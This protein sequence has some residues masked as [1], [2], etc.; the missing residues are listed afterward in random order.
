VTSGKL[1]TPPSAPYRGAVLIVVDL[2]ESS[3]S[4]RC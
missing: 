4:V 2:R 3:W 1:S